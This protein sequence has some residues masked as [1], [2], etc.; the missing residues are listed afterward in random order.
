MASGAIHFAVFHRQHSLCIGRHAHQSRHPHPEDC[1]RSANRN[2]HGDACDI[3]RTDGR[4]ERRIR[5]PNGYIA[6]VLVV[7][8]EVNS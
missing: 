8:V 1:T 7:L 4:G 3:T 5:A 2:R 6:F